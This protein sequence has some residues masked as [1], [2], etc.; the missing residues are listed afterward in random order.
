VDKLIEHIVPSDTLPPI[1]AEGAVQVHLQILSADVM[2]DASD[3]VL[4]QAPESFN[5]VDARIAKDVNTCRM[6]DVGIPCAAADLNKEL[7]QRKFSARQLR[8][9]CLGL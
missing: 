7:D 9:F 6:I 1:K 3:A 5:R 4:C 2:T 8:P